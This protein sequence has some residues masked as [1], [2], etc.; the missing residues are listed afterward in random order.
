MY[1]S[2]HAYK[3]P[4]VHEALLGP[5][6]QFLGARRQRK[7]QKLAPSSSLPLQLWASDS[8]LYQHAPNLA[9]V[10]QAG[11]AV[12]LRP[13]LPCTCVETKATVKFEAA[14]QANAHV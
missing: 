8:S 13:L 7:T 1:Q 9:N 10:N 4:I 5:T 2:G 11:S 14:D 3:A 6:S 12:L